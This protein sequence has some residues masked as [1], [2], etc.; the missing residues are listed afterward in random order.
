MVEKPA[1]SIVVCAYNRE[2]LIGKCLEHIAN[3]TN[4]DFELVIV[5]NNSTDRTEEICKTFIEKHKELPVH[6]VLEPKQGLCAAR[7]RGIRESKSDWIAYIDDDAFADE[8]YVEHFIHFVTHHPQARVCGGRIFPCFESKRPRWLSKYILPIITTL[9]KGDRVTFFRHRSYPVGAN[10]M[11]HRELFE[12]YGLFNEEMG[13]KGENRLVS[14]DEK[15]FFLRFLGKKIRAYY[16][17]DVSVRHWVPDSRLTKEFFD[18]Q[19]FTI[20]TSERIRAKNIS[21][22][23]FTKSCF[24]E[25][26]KW[27]AT[28]IL[29][30]YYMLRLNPSAANKLMVFR[31]NVTKSFLGLCK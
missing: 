4:K 8:A 15:E 6:L 20:G 3:Q 12:R 31:K 27:F 1:L 23:E 25:L 21:G 29:W 9:D 30:I 19:S 11:I 13:I 26:L 28:V 2:N 24:R 10:M 5:N 14:S 17:P 18:N 22:C 16:L 7:N